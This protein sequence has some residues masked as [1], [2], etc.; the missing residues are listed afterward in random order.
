MILNSLTDNQ[1]IQL[2]I[3][4]SNNEQL[5]FEANKVRH[6]IYG[7]SIFIRGLI[8]ITNY[9]KNNCFYCG[10]RYE[11]QQLDRYR[12][13]E[14]HIIKCCL[15]GYNLGFRTFV[16]QGGEDAFFSD[17][18]IC[19]IISRIKKEFSDCAITLSLG[20]KSVE[21]YKK[22]FDAGACRYLLRHETAM[23]NHYKMLHPSSMSLKN[24]KNCLFALKKIGYQV[25]SGFMVGSPY[26][27]PINI[28]QDIRFLQELSPD[29]IGIGPFISHPQTPF[30]DFPNG[31]VELTIKLISILRI[32]F[33]KAL[34]PATTALSTLC[35]SGRK[36]ALL[37]GANVIMPNLSP[38]EVRDKYQIYKNKAFLGTE[39][40]KQIE[41]IKKEVS[42]IGFNILIDK[43]DAKR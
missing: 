32:F 24:R 3:D 29:M 34:I 5:S 14:N 37:A 43:G 39:S 4:N 41:Q 13:L 36:A 9:C 40:A 15:D 33:P 8:E 23:E 35:K 21:S 28:V 20:E 7:D 31:S 19:K 42:S 26:Q 38:L 30:S 25:G 2:I 6:E 11:N 1:L 17:E 22:M 18:A 10:I 16:L 27:T 12:L